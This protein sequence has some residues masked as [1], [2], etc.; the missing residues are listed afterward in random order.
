MIWIL[1]LIQKLGAE[2]PLSRS[3]TETVGGAKQRQKT[4][5]EKE[6]VGLAK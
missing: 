2:P 3:I 1:L 6:N 5:Q 4:R